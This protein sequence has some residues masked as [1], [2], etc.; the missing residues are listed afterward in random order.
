MST[1]TQTIIDDLTGMLNREVKPRLTTIAAES[2]RLSKL[3]R[4]HTEDGSAAREQLEGD[5]KLVGAHLDTF[6]TKIESLPGDLAR[7]DSSG[8]RD[9]I[10]QVRGTF[11]LA[12]DFSSEKMLKAADIL[13]MRILDQAGHLGLDPATRRLFETTAG[14]IYDEAKSV[15]NTVDLIIARATE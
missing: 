14:T 15:Y 12:I 6:L 7:I 2:S 8:P 11:D 9:L 4:N 5:L 13:T 3:V 10:H 1:D